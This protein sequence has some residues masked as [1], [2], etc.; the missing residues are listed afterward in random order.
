MHQ[1]RQNII[2][3]RL[4]MLAVPA[5]FGCFDHPDDKVAGMVCQTDDNCP[6]GYR[7]IQPGIVGGC[8]KQNPSIDGGSSDSTIASD[9]GRRETV[10]DAALAPDSYNRLEAGSSV[11]DAEVDRPAITIDAPWDAHDNRV[12]A[13][14][15]A[16]PE[17]LDVRFI[18]AN[19][20]ATPDVRQVLP[21]DGGAG[22]SQGSD[23]VVASGGMT[24]SGGSGGAGGVTGAGGSTGSGGVVS[25]G[26]IAS[27]GGASS[28]GGSSEPGYCVLGFS[29][30]EQC[31]LAP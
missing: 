9:A 21:V 25:S 23:G 10:L 8:S 22:G 1:P 14:V 26:G 19:V 31:K 18:D 15:G 16:T 27:S 20:D 3:F 29:P 7:C 2:P 17:V 11:L 4:L 5:L 12:D 24:G 30:I 6:R 13:S 28:T